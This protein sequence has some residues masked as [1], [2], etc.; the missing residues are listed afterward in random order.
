M[1]RRA[2]AVGLSILSGIALGSIA[3]RA[4]G[5]QAQVAGQWLVQYEHEVRGVHVSPAPVEIA[6]ARM[7]LQLRG[8]SVVGAWEPVSAPGETPSPAREIRGRRLRDVTAQLAPAPEPAGFFLGLIAEV[9]EF[10]KTH[11]HG[12]PPMTTY[13]TFTVR[14]DSLVGTRRAAS[15]DGSVRGRLNALSGVRSR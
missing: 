15:A 9:V 3:G 1:Y 13:I 12:I 6:T 2:R 5:A 14:G 4:A 10:L 7:S 8:D 11:V